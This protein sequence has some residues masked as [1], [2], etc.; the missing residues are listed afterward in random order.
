MKFSQLIILVF[1]F[2]STSSCEQKSEKEVT[3]YT[4]FNKSSSD[5]TAKEFLIAVTDEEHLQYGSRVA[6]LNKK[7]DTIIPF[8]KYGYL[9]TDT[10]THYANVF[11][12]P[13]D[14]S[15]GRRIA[16]DRNQNILYDLVFFDNGPDYFHEGLV[17]VERNE[18]MGFANKYGQILIPCDYDFVWWFEKG[19]AKVTFDAREIRDKYD[20]HTRIESEE[21]FYIDR[22]GKRIK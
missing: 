9:G 15:S 14:T 10:L 2:I 1:S 5:S 21:W 6:Y 17:R 8:G 16:I 22:N 19:K 20:Y 13:T 12:Y 4:Y 11:E 18:K 3:N 7:G